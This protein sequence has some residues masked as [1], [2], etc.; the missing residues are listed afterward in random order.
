MA[1]NGRPS[2]IV[3]DPEQAARLIEAI[4][5]TTCGLAKI[6]KSPGMPNT[7]TVVKWRQMFPDF[8]AEYDR[9]KKEQAHI[10]V[11]EMIEIAD[12]ISQDVSTVAS[13]D[14]ELISYVNKEHIMR[15]KIRIETRKWIAS[16]LFPKYYGDR[17]LEVGAGR[18]VT[19]E[20]LEEDKEVT[21][22]RVV[23]EN[24]EVVNSTIGLPDSS[25]AADS[26]SAD[27]RG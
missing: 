18:I 23:F 1:Q 6:C 19:G 26:Q 14:G 10:M 15:S 25:T 12:D 17:L 7:Y 22:H 8:A 21:G 27:G 24:F 5:T 13:E 4:S 20:Q 16:K 9:A 3:F 2:E 11:D